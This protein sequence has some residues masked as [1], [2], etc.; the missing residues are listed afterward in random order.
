M[1]EKALNVPKNNIES[2]SKMLRI[3]L[4]TITVICHT[5]ICGQ[6]RKTVTLH[7]ALNTHLY[8]TLN[9]QLHRKAYSNAMLEYKIYK[10]SLLPSIEL[11]MTPISFNHSLKMLQNAVSGEYFNVEEF[12]NTTSV[13]LTI[14]QAINA[15]GGVFSLG[16]ALSY[17]GEFSTGVNSFSNSPLFANYSQKLF[18]GRK[19][20]R[21]K[22]KISEKAYAVALKNYCAAITTE[23]QTILNLYLDAY[24]AKLDKEYYSRICSIGDTIM[25][26]AKLRQEAGKITEYEANQIELQQLGNAVSLAKSEKEY[27]HAIRSLETEL[28]L[29]GID[30]CTPYEN[31]LPQLIDCDEVIYLVK[32]NNPQYQNSE[33]Q[34]LNAEYTLHSTKVENCFNANISITYGLNQYARTLRASYIRPNQQQAA[35]ITLSIPIWEWGA[36]RDR[37]KVAQNEYETTLLQQTAIMEQLNEQTLESVSS[38]NL[39]VKTVDIAKKRFIL[40]QRQY[41]FAAI[42]FTLGKMST[43]ELTSVEDELLK[44]KQEYMSVQKELFIKYYQ[45]RHLAMFDFIAKKD[46]IDMIQ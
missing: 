23:E 25:M 4:L 22:N 9:V 17:L 30:V 36:N 40:S 29:N 13:G 16:S 43:T 32:K 34:R 10:K 46:I 26:Y 45:I 41:E 2:Y 19:T 11:S 12:S 35:S 28:Q 18:G 39:C 31:N 5:L 24:S 14:R 27:T 1:E 38:Y 44:A 33:L 42:Q 8:N 15:T 6:E 3:V 20:L 7:D 37:I 21:Y